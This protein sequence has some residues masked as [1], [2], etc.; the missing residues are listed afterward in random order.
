MAEQMSAFR[1]LPALFERYPRLSKQRNNLGYFTEKNT[2]AVFRTFSEVVSETSVACVGWALMVE[3]G[4]VGAVVVAG[5]TTAGW[6]CPG[7]RVYCWI[8]WLWTV[9]TC[10]Q[11]L[12]LCYA[13]ADLQIL[14]VHVFSTFVARQMNDE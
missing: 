6:Q 2:V 13:L 3:I 4:V 11:A 1:S 7:W 14:P 9:K 8:A 10:K 5:G 12:L